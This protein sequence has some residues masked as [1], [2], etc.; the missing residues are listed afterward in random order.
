[1]TL[2]SW[3]DTTLTPHYLRDDSEAYSLPIVVRVERNEE[4]NNETAYIAVAKLMAE[5]FNQNTWVEDLQTWMKGRIR[6]VVRKARANAWESLKT[7]DHVYV[8]HE[9]VE[10]MAFKPHK[11]D[12]LNPILK[13]LQVQGIEFVQSTPNDQSSGLN[14]AVNPN[15]AMSTGKTLAQVAHAAQLFILQSPKTHV[16]QWQKNEYPVTIVPWETYQNPEITIQDAG[17]TEI[18]AG[19][20]TVKAQYQ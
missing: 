10:L 16:E 18:P 14:I 5:V 2:L 6:K 9:N 3:A 19:S 13:K 20:Y 12:E 15:L 4:Y 11:L 17:L 8:K 7:L 1:M